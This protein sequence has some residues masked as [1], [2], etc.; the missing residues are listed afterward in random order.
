VTINVAAVNDAPV[1]VADTL[2]GTEDTPLT[3]TAAQLLGNDTDV[4]NPSSALTIAS[5]TSGAVGTAVVLNG[6]VAFTPNSNFNGAAN[7]TYTVTDGSLVSAPATVKIN[8]AAVNDAP[9][10]APTAVLANGT[11]DVAYTVA[12]S[13]LLMGFSDPD[14]DV[15]AVANLVAS[16]GSVV[17]NGNGTFT[18]TEPANFNGAVTLTYDVTDGH[19]GTLTG[20]TR[21]YMVTAVNDAPV[22][23][24]DG[25][26]DSAAK[27]VPEHSTL[28]AILAATDPEA[29]QTLT[30]SISDGPPGL[31][32]LR[33]GPTWRAFL[34]YGM[35]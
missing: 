26:G 1:A 2:T 23:T 3:I 32:E 7:F 11:E 13:T 25:G 24:S 4:D 34:H 19:G 10:G 5:V 8:V 22:I 28:V 27:S 15:L 18:I 21:G 35:P 9:I 31:F 33:N 30:F 17:N 14:G 12:A 16:S 20:E 29:G 6:N